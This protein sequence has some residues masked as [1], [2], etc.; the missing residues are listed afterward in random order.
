MAGAKVHAI[1]S[2][3]WMGGC[4]TIWERLLFFF[5]AFPSSAGVSLVDSL[6]HNGKE[7]K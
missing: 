7:S 1:E 3:A 5:S 4:G 6:S 2:R